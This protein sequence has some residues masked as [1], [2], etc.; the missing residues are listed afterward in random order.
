[1]A[2]RAVGGFSVEFCGGEMRGHG[3]VMA[4]WELSGYWIHGQMAG[5]GTCMPG[6]MWV[7]GVGEDTEVRRK[8][9]ENF[10]SVWGIMQKESCSNVQ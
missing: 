9:K 1:M 7:L 6:Q 2:G 3:I 10:S 5:S 8:T 4:I